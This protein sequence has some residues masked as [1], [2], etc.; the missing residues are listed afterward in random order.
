MVEIFLDGQRCDVA[1]G[2]TLPGE[3]FALDVS[4]TADVASQRTGRTL[5]LE[6]PST[7]VND[8]LMMMAKDPCAGERFNAAEHRVE[9]RVDGVALMEGVAVLEAME[10]RE[11]ALCYKLKVRSGGSDWVK[12]AAL[13]KLSNALEYEATLNGDTISDSWKGDKK[14]RFMPVC[15]DDYRVP[16]SE[17]SLYPPQ[18]VMTVADYFPFLSIRYLV[19]AA[20]EKAGYELAGSWINRDDFTKL[21]MSG[22]YPQTGEASVTRLKNFAGFEAGRTSSAQAQANAAGRVWLTSQVLTSSLG[23]LVQTTEGEGLYCNNGSLTITQS[24][25]VVYHPATTQT[26]GFEYYL[27]YKTD[28]RIM[29][30]TRLKCFDSIYLGSGCDMNFQVANPFKDQR[31]LL[32][33]NMEYQC[34]VFDHVEGM[35]YRMLCYYGSSRVEVCRDV[36]ERFSFTTPMVGTT[37]TGVLQ[38]IDSN[39]VMSNYKGDWAIYEGY[40]S[41]IGEIEVEVTLQS[42]PET[43]TPSGRNFNHLYLHGA[44]PGQ[45]I[46]LL[47]ECRLRPIFT[48]SPALGSNLKFED[49]AA[50]DI[51]LIEVV[52]A[53]QQMY[54]LRIYTDETSRKVYLLPYNSFY[55]SDLHDWSHKV[56]L[57]SPIEVEDV[58]LGESERFTL[59]YRM[60]GDGAVARFNAQAESPF[61]EWSSDIESRVTVQGERRHTNPLF[62]PTISTQ[63]FADI[64]NAWV[65]QVGDRDA[66][67]VGAVSV[68]VVRYEGLLSLPD[69]QCWG[70][71]TYEQRYPYVYFHMPNFRTLCF[72]D[73]DN[74]SGMHRYYDKELQQKSLRRRVR[75]TLH[76]SALELKSLAEWESKGANLR[77]TFVLNLSGQR[78]TY[79]LEA[80]ESYDAAT[81]R[82]VCRFIRTLND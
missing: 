67:Q 68:R 15:F 16:Y 5:K 77:S 13:T 32:Q 81:Q 75:L 53:L 3:V 73:R 23:N 11:G 72:E 65:L 55:R 22:R 49:V 24:D 33:P 80:V 79:N 20:V 35:R 8:A 19:A 56:D 26:V 21:L 58:A 30:R 64:P 74:L 71:P 12:S 41:E 51:Q 47:P 10:Y 2:Y 66:D 28:Y 57:G 27:K 14:V 38:Q 62:T 60:E 1:E 50:H 82:A 29:S 40:V 61:G 69:S 39:G 54:N 31:S 36:G 46:T 78:A 70:F 76:L 42:P 44:E 59:A 18:R 17:T 7:D 37:L 43:V 45:N 63:P 9:I 4:S 25:G 6:L 52:E 48:A 34:I